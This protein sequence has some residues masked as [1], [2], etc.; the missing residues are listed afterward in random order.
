MVDDIEEYNQ[1][2]AQRI[3]DDIKQSFDFN[4]FSKVMREHWERQQRHAFCFEAGATASH[5][6]GQATPAKLKRYL[7]ANTPQATLQKQHTSLT[8]SNLEVDFHRQK[9]HG[10]SLSQSM[11]APANPLAIEESKDEHPE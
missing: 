10:L 6:D 2:E 3:E 1:A 4:L 11:L 8:N 9:S 5:L 7:E